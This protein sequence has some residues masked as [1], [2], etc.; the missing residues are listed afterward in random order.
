VEYLDLLLQTF[1]ISE[2]SGTL[3]IILHQ[4][5][6]QPMYEKWP[7]GEQAKWWTHAARFHIL[8]QP[9]EFRQ[10]I[11]NQYY[12]FAMLASQV[13]IR[14]TSKGSSRKDEGYKPKDIQG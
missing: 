10:Y 11:R 3:P 2:D 5:N 8:D 7:S 6:L 13:P 9:K 1:D 12:V 14:S 4:N